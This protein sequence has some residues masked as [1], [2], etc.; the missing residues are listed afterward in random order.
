VFLF[1]YSRNPKGLEL[2]EIMVVFID[3]HAVGAIFGQEGFFDQ[4]RIKFE[5]DY[6]VF[7]ITSARKR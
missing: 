3:S 7:E 5:K 2:V 4:H 6:N 1:Q